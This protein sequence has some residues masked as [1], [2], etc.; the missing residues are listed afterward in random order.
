MLVSCTEIKKASMEKASHSNGVVINRLDKLETDFILNESSVSMQEMALAYPE[1]ARILIEDVLRI[2]S[3]DDRDIES[4]LKSYFTT[5]S[6]RLQLIK[7]VSRKYDNLGVYGKQLKNA[8]TKLQAEI[9][10]MHIPQFYAQ[11]SGFNQSIVVGDSIL[12]ISLDKYMGTDYEPY[13]QFYYQRQIDQMRPSHI[14]GDCLYFWL[15]SKNPPRFSKEVPLLDV[16]LHFGKINWIVWH[17]L[18]DD[19][20]SGKKL[21]YLKSGKSSEGEWEEMA[22]KLLSKDVLTLTDEQ[23]IHY[24]LFGMP[25]KKY[26][27]F[28]G[29]QGV[30][31]PAGMKIIDD[32]M[33][34]HPQ[35]TLQQ[36]L[37][38]DNSAHILQGAGYTTK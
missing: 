26:P 36:L 27:K 1:E 5:N 10:G 33:R 13:S 24:I 38:E 7:D 19:F 14:V 31:V 2:G 8:F 6:A 21:Y 11:I 34:L 16:L 18:G 15:E 32:Y 4:K 20:R 25:G 29:L 30:G 12:G 9:P 37:A 22:S 17:I 3:V 35:C 28:K 23:A